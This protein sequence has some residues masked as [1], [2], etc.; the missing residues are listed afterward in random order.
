MIQSEL[1]IRGADKIVDKCPKCGKKFIVD[2]IPRRPATCYNDCIVKCKDC[3]IGISNNPNKPTI[4]YDNYLDNIPNELHYKL[5]YILSN[6]LNKVS[7]KQK[8]K[9]IGFST[10]EDALSWIFFSYFLKENKEQNLLEL[11][12][13]DE[14]KVIDI[15]FWGCGYYNKDLSGKLK[16]ILKEVFHEDKN[17]FSEP[18]V[19][20][21]TENKMIFIEVKYQSINANKC[22][23]EEIEKYLISDYY[24]DIYLARNSEYYELIRNWSIGNKLSGEKE[25]YL[26]NIGLKN[27]FSKENL[28]D[29]YNY[30]INSL[31]NESRFKRFYWEG[32][33][34]DLKMKDIDSWYINEM[35]K[36]IYSKCV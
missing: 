24:K 7:R 25:F 31:K 16:T 30:F 15:Y 26:F 11:F 21:E 3:K 28:D 8:I 9:R 19:I 20:M 18:D 34:D 23:K 35:C 4:I 2:N 6:S 29:K 32:L 17:K 10:S 1:K 33:I 36:R 14:K 12:N 5:D 22:N 27:N 13:I